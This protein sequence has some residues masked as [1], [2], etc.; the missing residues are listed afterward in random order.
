MTAMQNLFKQQQRTYDSLTFTLLSLTRDLSFFSF[1]SIR[2]HWIFSEMRNW[3][4]RLLVCSSRLFSFLHF[5]SIPFQVDSRNRRLPFSRKP[6]ESI[7]EQPSFRRSPIGSCVSVYGVRVL[8]SQR[9]TNGEN[10]ES[11][12]MRAF[13]KLNGT[14]FKLS[15]SA[16]RTEMRIILDF[17]GCVVRRCG[18][19]VGCRNVASSK[20]YPYPVCLYISSNQY[21]AS[22][23]WCGIVLARWRRS[24][25]F[26]F[27][28]D[29]MIQMI[30]VRIWALRSLR[31]MCG[32]IS[33]SKSGKVI[34]YRI[35]VGYLFLS[36]SLLVSLVVALT[37]YTATS[38]TS[39]R[40]T[41]FKCF[42]HAKWEFHFGC[43][44]NIGERHG[45]GKSL[46]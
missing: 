36:F 30:R 15:A 19:V 45:L 11:T 37:H 17:I 28:F 5:S 35:D 4:S 33:Y 40:M 44:M 38:V 6:D 41:E 9:G 34:R 8:C 43:E 7:A 23:M 26:D 18:L 25:Q 31:S 21:V 1:H 20:R 29:L 13:P 27:L 12:A 22:G 42:T 39:I 10:E 24:H 14:N 2:R 16:I 46:P 32:G 3:I